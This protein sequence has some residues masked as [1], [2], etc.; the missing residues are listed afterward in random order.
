MIKFI[1]ILIGLGIIVVILIVILFIIYKGFI[2][3]NV[4]VNSYVC[5][6]V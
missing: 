2:L 6:N 5:E 4:S 3:V 1:I